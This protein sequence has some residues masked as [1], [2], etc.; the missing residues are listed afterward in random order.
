MRV[1]GWTSRTA[2]VIES[3]FVLQHIDFAGLSKI[4]GK[5]KSQSKE[6]PGGMT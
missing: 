1:N 3:F 2:M 5:R 6:L 4:G